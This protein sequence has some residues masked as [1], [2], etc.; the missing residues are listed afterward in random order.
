MHSVCIQALLLLHVAAAAYILTA[1]L[2]SRNESSDVPA[3]CGD[4]LSLLGHLDM[5]RSSASSNRVKPVFVSQA[6]V[7]LKQHFRQ[8]VFSLIGLYL[9]ENY[10]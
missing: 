4:C 9:F 6:F 10:L 5:L 7:S 1:P 3:V 2:W 8:F